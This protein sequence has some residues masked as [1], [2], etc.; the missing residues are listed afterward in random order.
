ME[1]LFY[2]KAKSDS[3]SKTRK[4][5]DNMFGPKWLTNKI[6]LV[7]LQVQVWAPMRH[8]HIGDMLSVLSSAASFSNISDKYKLQC[9]MVFVI[10]RCGWLDYNS[11]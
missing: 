9:L 1:I 10:L 3:Q 2:I 11:K 5:L 6:S 7:H 4:V 8:S